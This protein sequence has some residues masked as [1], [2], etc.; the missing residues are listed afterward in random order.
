M[1][2]A[3]WKKNDKKARL[4]IFVFSAIVFAAVVLL[5]R[6]KLEANLGFDIHL[7][8]KA[9]AIINSCVAILHVFVCSFF[10]KLYLSSLI[11]RRN[12]VWRYK[13]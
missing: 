1:L 6:V 7:F 4:L 3:A 2:Q 5:S 11:C 10:G 13:P 8:A 9:N 12:K